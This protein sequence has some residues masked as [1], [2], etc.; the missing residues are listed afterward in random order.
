M[1]FTV[2]N[3]LNGFGVRYVFQ[4]RFR[5]IHPCS[6][7]VLITW[8]KFASVMLAVHWKG[9]IAGKIQILTANIYLT[10]GTGKIGNLGLVNTSYKNCM[11]NPDCIPLPL[12]FLVSSI[13]PLYY[14]RIDFQTHDFV[15]KF[16]SNVL[17]DNCWKLK[18]Q[19]QL[20]Y[21]FSTLG[22]IS[23]FDSEGTFILHE[24]L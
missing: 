3:F 4:R 13:L 15:R 16:Q 24:R 19:F 5:V 8:D 9:Q 18:A 14:H 11:P 7:G 10:L 23:M 22:I 2:G 17:G 20:H 21:A 12:T 1:V 6:V